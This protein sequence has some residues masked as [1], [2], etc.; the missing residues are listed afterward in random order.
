MV[1]VYSSTGASAS[2]G[3]PGKPLF[4]ALRAG[5]PLLGLPGNPASVLVNLLVY[6]RRALDRLEGLAEP[7]P[8]F[9]TGVLD[10]AVDTDPRDQWL[11]MSLRFDERGHARLRRLPKQASHM[12]SN[13]AQAGAL[14]WIP[15]AADPT[16][17]GAVVRWL[18]L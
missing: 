3:N 5:V 12:L 17:R 13:L 16:P 2:A 7:G 6:V 18:A 8:A 14:A 10:D 15:R 11:R 4:A 9:S 1:S